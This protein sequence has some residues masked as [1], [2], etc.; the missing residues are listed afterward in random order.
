MSDH[1]LEPGGALGGSLFRRFLEHLSHIREPRPGERI[2]AWKIVRELGR[3]GSGVVYLAERADGA[4]SQEVALKWLRSD[5]PVPGGRDVLRR[6]RELLAAL[7]HP[8]IARLVD[9]GETRD[10]MLWFA[11]DYVDG[12]TIDRAVAGLDLAERLELV[13]ILCQAV[14][15]AHRR[16]LIHGDIKPSNVLVD[17][18]GHPR[19]LDFGISR[20]KGGRAGG[21]YGLTPDYASPEQRR[22]EPLTTASDIWQLGRLLDDM[23]GRDPVAGDLRAIVTRATAETPE[24]R[25][26]SAAAMGGDIQAWLEH[27]PVAAHRGGAGYRL[28]RL[29]QRN[30][31]VSTVAGTALVVIAFGGV[32]MT[33]KLADE[34]DRARIEAE[35]A[36]AALDETEAALARA[37]ALGDFLTDLFEATRPD[38]PRD[39]LPSTEEILER[40]AERAMDPASAPPGERFDM[41]STIG[42]V[43]RARSRYDDAEPLLE[44]ALA[45]AEEHDAVSTLDRVRARRQRARLMIASGDPLEDAE[46]L[47]IEAEALLAG[48]SDAWEE[49]A[50]VRITR[51]WV[52]RHRGRHDRALALLEPVFWQMPGPQTVNDST[53][54]SLFDG[55]AGLV[56]ASGD[57]D[58]AARFRDLALDT[59]RQAQGPQGQG[60]VVSLANSVGLEFSR[61]N[62]E[63][64]ERRARRALSVYDRIYTEPVDYRA[65]LRRTLA[66]VL[67]TVGRVDEAFE[68]LRRS[69]EEYARAR[70]L[71]A[72]QWPL[73]YST[74]GH[75]TARLGNHDAAVADL[76]RDRELMREQQEDFDRPLVVTVDLLL[77]WTRC[78]QGGNGRPLLDEVESEKARLARSRQR[79]LLREARATCQWQAGNAEPALEGIE[80][81]LDTP[82]RPA[83]LV[84]DADRR[85][86]QARILADLDRPAEAMAALEQAEAVFIEHDLTPH[87]VLARVR[88]LRRSLR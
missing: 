41:L 8:N 63:Q 67:L 85:I 62:F 18:R 59:F 87:P 66:R 25:Y 79:A 34:R 12:E 69:G 54:A 75:F 5:R 51:T 50:R 70:D 7:D 33:L 16:G 28:A 42:Q 13:R 32:W 81:L 82:P 4:Y 88:E 68:V 57:L 73:Y 9:G 24:E 45:L 35:R 36:E 84:D 11:L 58:R 17:E 49:L 40:G 52:E 55:L 38:R 2:G 78:R 43:Y 20:L 31:L 77:A 37:E 27:R 56:A 86:V 22:H 39:Q 74:R 23:I 29:V 64:A 26:H 1:P 60:Y 48:E 65:A 15:H 46:A 47:L 10:G 61:G 53:R 76:E 44:A 6:E 21:S 30:R 3:G 80:S 71:E 83:R 72:G 14:Q 19:L